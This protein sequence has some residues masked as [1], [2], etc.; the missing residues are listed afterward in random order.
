MLYLKV[1]TV[2]LYYL[3]PCILYNPYQSWYTP[4]SIENSRI[5]RRQTDESRKLHSYSCI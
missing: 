1:S 4:R 5:S 2:K 3:V